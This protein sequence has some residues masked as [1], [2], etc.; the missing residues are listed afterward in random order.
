MSTVLIIDDSATVRQR[1]QEVLEGEPK[2]TRVVSAADGIAGFKQLM[3]QPI[4]LI[5]C[6]L[7]MPV[8]DGFKFL[9]LKNTRPEFA[10]VPVIMLTG[11]ED[12]RAK[13]RGL[14]AGALDYLTKPFDA[15]EL[16]ARVRIHLKL[17]ELQ[18]D[19]RQKNH[20]LEQLTR[21]DELTGLNNRRFFMEMLNHEFR[22]SERY[23]TPLVFV[24]VDIDHF[25]QVND[26]YGHLMGDRALVAVA[27][28]LARTARAQDLVGRFGGE[29]FAI[30]MPHTELK[31]GELAA[32]RHRRLIEE[33]PIMLDQGPLKVTASFGVASYPRSDVARVEE[34]VEL[35]DQALYK[36][37]AAGRNCVELAPLPE[38]AAPAAG[39]A[40]SP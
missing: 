9:A 10:D 17:K 16:L 33:E 25:K 32:L 37:K 24:M 20:R 34:L 27:Q 12:I 26:R 8:L 22:R 11:E 4:D 2:V 6:D 3:E 28:V 1:V 13:V 29:E 15:H 30:I 38:P 5:L 40:E 36:A 35:A 7:V 21:V 31:G 18:D 23:G 39:A 19:L 14:E